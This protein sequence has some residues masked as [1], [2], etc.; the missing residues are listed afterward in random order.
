MNLLFFL[1]LLFFDFWFLLSLFSSCFCW[2]LNHC[3][4]R[5]YFIINF[6]LVLSVRL[7]FIFA[8]LDGRRPS[9]NFCPILFAYS[10]RFSLRLRLR[11]NIVGITTKQTFLINLSIELNNLESIMVT[12]QSRSFIGSILTQKQIVNIMRDHELTTHQAYHH[13]RSACWIVIFWQ[14]LETL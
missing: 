12:N 3:L 4:S 10:L 9:H 7:I 6:A 2:R 13:T 14:K 1:F 5:M 8:C 11:L